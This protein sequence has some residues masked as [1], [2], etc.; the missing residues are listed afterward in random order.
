VRFLC[1]K[2]LLPTLLLLH[3]ASVA[4]R[5]T[6][7]AIKSQISALGQEV[8]VLAEKIRGLEKERTQIGEEI[9]S[10]KQKIA[11]QERQM[12]ALMRLAHRLGPGEGL[13][14]LLGDAAP[15]QLGRLRVYQ[16]QFGHARSEQ[17]TVFR[18]RLQTLAHAKQKNRA[19]GN[20]LV[21]TREESLA[22]KAALEKQLQE[23]L[24]TASQKAVPAPPA[25][26]FADMRGRLAWPVPVTPINRFGDKRAG[27]R[28]RWRGVILPGEEGS[29]VQAIHPGRVVFADWFGDQGLLLVLN[30]GDG[31]MSL[32]GS[33]SSLLYDVDS[34]VEDGTVIATVGHSGDRE[35]SGLYF[36]I[37]HRGK[38]LNPARWCRR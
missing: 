28:L 7:Q 1:A 2:I 26:A 8:R 27:G 4:A 25:V 24:Q 10:S 12:R 6:E 29:P 21:K 20:T 34:D 38:P 36:E 31:Y 17:L 11:A 14:S 37:R 9:I 15:G 33:N 16:K 35:E 30:H 5:P 13:R 22:K 23:L 19:L 18:S 32:Y 3:G